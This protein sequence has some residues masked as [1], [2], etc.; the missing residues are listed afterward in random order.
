MKKGR[1]KIEVLMKENENENPYFWCICEWTGRTWYNTGRMGRA[2]TAHL[3]WEKAHREYAKY[4]DESEKCKNCSNAA[5][6]GDVCSDCFVE[7]LNY[8]IYEHEDL[9]RKCLDVL[10]Y[11][12]TESETVIK[13]IDEV[14]GGLKRELDLIK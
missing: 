8:K 2:K 6:Y 11:A 12:K 13:G 4:Y 5:T 10:D 14:I 1:F 7:R 9:F 3:A